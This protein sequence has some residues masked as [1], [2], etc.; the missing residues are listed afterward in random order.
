[1]LVTKQ[2]SEI[3]HDAADCRHTFA[4]SIR[5]YHPSISKEVKY[6]H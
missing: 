5:L 6:E 4:S 2:F 3:D 1:M